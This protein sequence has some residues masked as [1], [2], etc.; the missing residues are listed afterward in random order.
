MNWGEWVMTFKKSLFNKGLFLSDVKRFSWV[1]LLYAGMLFFILPFNHIMR[2]NALDNEWVRHQIQNSLSF[3]SSNATQVMLILVI[4]IVLAVLIFR[5][6]QKTNAAALMHSLP[7]GRDTLYFSHT[8]AGLLLLCLPVIFIGFILMALQLTTV[9]GNYYSFANVL[10]WLNHTLLF[11][12]LFFS[13]AVFVGM[14]TGSSV[15]HI[16]FTYIL[17]ILPAGIYMLFQY[18]LS[19]LIYGYNNNSFFNSI[20]EK[21]PFFRLLNFR[22]GINAEYLPAGEYISYAIITVLF[23]VVAYY[24][25]KIRNIESAGD[26]I[27]FKGI[28]PVFKYGVT[29]CSMLLGGLYFAA[30]SGNSFSIIAFGYFFSSFI[31]YLVAEILLE[32]SFKVWKAYKGY[33]AYTA[34]LIIF[35]IGVQTDVLGYVGRVPEIQDVENVFLGSSIYQWEHF[36]EMQDINSPYYREGFYYR[37]DYVFDD[38]ESIKNIITLHQTLIDKPSKKGGSY[39]YIAYKLK[40]GKQ[41]V[42]QYIINNHQHASALKPIYESIDYKQIRFPVIRQSHEEIKLIEITDNRSPKKPLMLT[43]SEEIKEFIEMFKMDIHRSNYEELI[44]DA[45]YT[46]IISI[47]TNDDNRMNYPL[48]ESHTIVY[49]WLKDKGAYEDIM[50]LPEDID[51]VRL[52]NFKTAPPN[53]VEIRDLEVIEELLKL[54]SIVDY[55]YTNQPIYVNFYI[56]DYS[57]HSFHLDGL[58]QDIPISTKLQSYLD[59]LKE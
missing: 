53:R 56:N 40:N 13:S 6:M 20:L 55:N 43:D 49:Q 10:Q 23:I 11:N 33:I 58:P 45:K 5:Y 37:D 25:Y 54:S 9:L 16:V 31:G 26:I 42:R 3:S 39:R 27:S 46:P 32:K 47:M 17:H 14:F 34:F 1:S 2:K 12:I 19:Q 28:R 41:L 29:L 24:V 8:T 35:L 44:I 50:L 52:E 7:C 18:N 22:S 30:I 48:Y 36:E 51:F 38:P 15:A 21:L 4:P 57:T 59:Q